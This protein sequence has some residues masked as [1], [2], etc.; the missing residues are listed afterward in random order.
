MASVWRHPRSKFF[1]A[2]FRDGSGK[3]RRISTK[4]TNWR[5]AQKLAE[6][7]EKATREKRTLRQAQRVLDRLQEELS[8][9]KVLRVSLRSYG[10]EWL[11]AK[12]PSV[13]ASSLN[14]YRKLLSKLLEHLGPKADQPLSEITKSDLV[15]L[16]NS[17]A[18]RLS[19]AT[20]NHDLGALK[21]LFRSA[22]RDG[23]LADD[24]A[25][26]VDPVR[27]SNAER[28][29]SRRPFTIPELQALLSVADPEWCSLIKIGLYTGG[30]LGDVAALRWT[31]IDLQRGELRFV[32][33]KTGKTAVIPLIG[34]LRIHIE[35][36]PA[37]DDSRAFLHPR[38][39]KIVENKSRCAPLSREF[40]SL[41]VEA[42]LRE[43]SP[44][45][46]EA[47]HNGRRN[48][49][50]LSFHCLRHTAVRLL[51]DAGIPQ[52]TVQELVGHSS[53]EMSALYTHVGRES[54]ERA[55]A[56]L[57]AL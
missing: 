25:E 27:Q 21:M 37:G 51:K 49:N 15:G 29:N 40:G 8:G 22:R 16:R 47:G 19:P 53:A 12:E 42:G 30:R 34:A 6:E 36:L 10:T 32:A 45:R 2:C 17:L 55:A 35:T 50:P 38:A 20:V 57:P 41:L 4:A 26:F 23:Y 56:A 5:I 13:K 9:H 14:F 7:F 52:A 39:A 54:L 44:Y 1:T 11:E 18:G 46:T 31:N 33:R 28:I 43:A 24:P 48:L 3:Q